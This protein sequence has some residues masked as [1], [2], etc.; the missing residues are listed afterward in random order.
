MKEFFGVVAAIGVIYALDFVLNAIT[1]EDIE[2]IEL[3]L[4]EA[5]AN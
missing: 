1:D 2:S 4:T 3:G 5:L